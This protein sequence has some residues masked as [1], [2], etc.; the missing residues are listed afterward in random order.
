VGLVA[1]VGVG[2]AATVSAC[3]KTMLHLRAHSFSVNPKL[4]T[5]LST[6][7]NHQLSIACGVC[8]HHMLLEIANRITVVGSDTTA[9][10]ARQRAGS[11][12]SG[13]EGDNT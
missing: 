1:G 7:P 4:M 13:V 10:E 3:Q 11:H 8:K 2:V 9:H 5:K 6:I 12:N